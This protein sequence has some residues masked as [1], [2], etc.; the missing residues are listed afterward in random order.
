[1]AEKA[2]SKLLPVDYSIKKELYHLYD[3]P[4]ENEAEEIFSDGNL[5]EY[6]E[7]IKRNAI[8]EV[9]IVVEKEEQMKPPGPTD[10]AERVRDFIVG[11]E[12]QSKMKKKDSTKHLKLL[13]EP[14]NDMEVLLHR[15]F[16]ELNE[17]RLSL[18]QCELKLQKERNTRV[19]LEEKI[20]KQTLAYRTEK[21]ELLNKTEDEIKKRLKQKVGDF[22][23]KYDD[24]IDFVKRQFHDT[25]MQMMDK[26]Q[27]VL[28]LFNMLIQQEKLISY[29]KQMLKI[30]NL[31]HV[32]LESLQTQV[33][34][35]TVDKE[36][37]MLRIRVAN[38]KENYIDLLHNFEDLKLLNYKTTEDWSAAE[39][40]VKDLEAKICDL[41]ELH[42]LEIK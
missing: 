9:N 4:D 2:L 37:K 18:N 38:L 28:K 14:K 21:Q 23:E 11:Q 26:E 41:N 19:K 39:H 27:L 31:G 25:R 17:A 30:N 34:Q 24:E 20:A 5:E 13:N 7:N 16:K 33:P 29:V 22:T 40:K 8:A 6:W 36:L 42:Q 35:D 32:K 1:M 3:A 12:R 15:K 10:D